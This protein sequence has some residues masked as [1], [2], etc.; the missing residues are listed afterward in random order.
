MEKKE[1]T[2]NPLLIGIKDKKLSIRAIQLELELSPYSLDTLKAMNF[3]EIQEQGFIPLQKRE[4]ITDDL[5]EA[6]GFRTDYQFITKSR[7]KT[8]QKKVKEKN[9]LPYFVMMRKI[10]TAQ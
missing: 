6:W 1:T 8:I 9:K 10:A 4:A 5:P 3:A 2:Y 7:M